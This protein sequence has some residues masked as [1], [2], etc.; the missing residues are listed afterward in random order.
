MQWGANGKKLSVV[1]QYPWHCM[2]CKVCEVCQGKGD[3]AQI[4]FCD[5]CDRGWH[6]YCLDPP[7]GKP[8]R[9]SWYCPTCQG[10]PKAN[11]KKAP[12][13]AR[14]A[15]P[16]IVRIRRSKLEGTGKRKRMR[17]DESESD[18]DASDTE[19]ADE[20][21]FSGVL[22]GDDA[23]TVVNAPGDDDTARFQ[24]SRQSAEIKLGTAEASPLDSRTLRAGPTNDGSRDSRESSAKGKA[25]AL[26]ARAT[27]AESGQATPMRMIRFGHF[28]IDTWFHAPFPEEYSL[29][30]DG[31]LWVCEFCFKYMKS[32]FMAER[33]RLKCRMRHPP[34]D[35]IYR[36]GGISVFEVDGRKNKIYCQ[37]L[38]LLAKL[39]LDHK[40]LYYDV[41]PFLFYVFVETDNEGSHF[42][43]Y[44]SKEKRSPLDYNVSCI[45]TLPIHQRRGWGYYLIEF[46]T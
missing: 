25:D 37:N 29:L 43:G 19:K 7:L 44:F 11:E 45:M 40:T 27:A 30:P 10:T 17:R 13:P 31:R 23:E 39:F 22:F 8:P 5:R 18:S 41:E 2:E 3:D 15:P 38:C 42:V 16:T 1:R 9:G 28:D 46:S 24:S 34:G 6:L 32:R 14:S 21:H 4:M 33:H 26:T 36:S 20:G 12:T 35:E